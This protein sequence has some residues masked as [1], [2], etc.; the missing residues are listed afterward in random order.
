MRPHHDTTPP[1]HA[2]A[3]AH[4]HSHGGGHG[5]AAGVDIDWNE[6]ADEME[7]QAGVHLGVVLDS[8]AWLRPRLTDVTRV[9]DVGSGT[10]V[11]AAAFAEAFPEAEVVAVDGAAGLL[12]RAV[13][14][15]QGRVTTHLAEL[16]ERADLDA[17]PDADL[18]WASRVVHH[19]GDQQAALD[20]LARRVRP[21][22][23]LAISEGGLPQRVLPRDIGVGRPGL[24]ARLDAANEEWFAVMRETLPDA[25]PVVEDW[26]AMLTRAGLVEAS[27]R[28]FVTELR[29]PLDDAARA[30]VHGYLARAHESLGDWLDEEDRGTLARLLDPKDPASLH[31]RTDTF[32]LTATTVH[33]ARAPR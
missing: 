29:A 22:G 24:Q 33:T 9:L 11:A 19:L 3:H 27:S 25:T 23:L 31:R 30:V 14:R 16:S 17:L 1:T 10:G 18:V 28:S 7:R 12:E 5:A 6:M 13:A 15:G 4:A 21:G 26:P 32:Y 8:I 2:H 20:A